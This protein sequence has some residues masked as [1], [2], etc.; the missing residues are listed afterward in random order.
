MKIIRYILI[1]LVPVYY[2]VTRF[3]N[4]FYDWG[5]LTSEAY[6]FPVICVGNLSVGGTGK[7]PMIE[8]LIYLL[9]K[10]NKL[11]T[12]S[13]GYKRKT[14]GFVLAGPEASPDQIGDEPFQFFNKFPDIQVAVDSNRRNGIKSLM[15]L[16]NKP[17]IVLLDDA[18]Q[19]RRVKA[20]LNIL[21][22]AYDDLY[23]D[24]MVL[25][26]GNLREPLA[27]AKRAQLIVVTKCPDDLSEQEKGSIRNKLRPND[28]QKLFF[29]KIS[30]SD[31]VINDNSSL[32]LE[33]LKEK[34][35]TLVTGIATPSPLVSYLKD[36]Q[37]N[38]EHL[39]YKDHHDFSAQ[40]I[41][42]LNSKELVLTTEKDFVRIS[43]KTDNQNI[44]YLPIKIEIDK[45]DQ[46]NSEI[47]KFVQA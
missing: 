7:T 32:R 18:F 4:K 22:T 10:S 15:A 13:R 24:D 36:Q 39:E 5:I 45:K 9:G 41:E 21:L 33:T 27:G 23:V 26:T 8:Y 12:L 16:K 19:H 20:G 14:K 3:R 38:F 17:E 2:L 31:H 40:D 42:G 46:F 34:S 25:P 43:T 37:L 44:W 28:N 35:I 47:M 11:A 30:Y 6:D 29:S 1:F